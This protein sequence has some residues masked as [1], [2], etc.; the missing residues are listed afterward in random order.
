MRRNIALIT[1]VICA[2]GVSAASATECNYDIK[3]TSD[4]EFFD[5]G[6]VLRGHRTFSEFWNDL[7]DGAPTITYS[8][9]TTN[10]TTTL[11]WK[12]VPAAPIR[13]GD[14]V[15]FGFTTPGGGC[16]C[17]DV[18]WT[19]DCHNRVEGSFVG[20]AQ[21][22][23][24]GTTYE[25]TNNS[26]LPIT[27]TNPRAA[28]QKFPLELGALNATNEYLSQAMRPIGSSTSTTLAPGETWTIPF[29]PCPECYCVLNFQ[30]SGEGLSAV[31]SPYAQER[32]P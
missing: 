14:W 7:G 25:I 16:P 19:D 23:L 20:A 6:I 32:A 27:V 3:N 13:P 2:L 15:H 22:H 1:L 21:N 11:H 24:N 28:C 18:F 30:T 10:P 31:L 12:K 29:N 26:F 9:G 8:G 17:I 4:K 5:V